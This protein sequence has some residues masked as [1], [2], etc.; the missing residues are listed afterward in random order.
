MPICDECGIEM[1]KIG[2]CG[3][4]TYEEKV[5]SLYLFQCPKCKKVIIG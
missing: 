2:K 3:E 1:E 4:E 5:I